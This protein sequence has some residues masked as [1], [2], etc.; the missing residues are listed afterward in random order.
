MEHRQIKIGQ[1]IN[2]GAGGIRVLSGF[3]PRKKTA[4]DDLRSL[5]DIC[6]NDIIKLP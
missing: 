3:C 5:D 2:L 6:A 4:L 1:L